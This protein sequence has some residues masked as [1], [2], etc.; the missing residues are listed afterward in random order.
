MAE[1]PD[2]PRLFEQLL[3]DMDAERE[4]YH[5]L[6]IHKKAVVN[7]KDYFKYGLKRNIRDVKYNVRAFYHKHTR[8]YDDVAL[9]DFYSQA[10]LY[11]YRVLSEWR[12]RGINGCPGRWGCSKCQPYSGIGGTISPWNCECKP[13]QRWEAA[14]DDMI[15]FHQVC[16]D[17]YFDEKD[18]DKK[19]KSPLDF[20][21]LTPEDKKRYRRGKFYYMK[22]YESLWD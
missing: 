20:Y 11:A 21:M 19:Y 13:F 9:W 4:A 3:A 16:A 22:Y 12:K 14:I 18:K 5:K 1:E 6:P 8:G 15:F 2:K 7:I 17:L 10:S